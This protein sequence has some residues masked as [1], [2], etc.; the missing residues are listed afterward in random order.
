MDTQ[1]V[2]YQ[3]GLLLGWG[4]C[5]LVFQKKK[6]PFKFMCNPTLSGFSVPRVSILSGFGRHLGLTDAFGFALMLVSIPCH[7]S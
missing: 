3:P 4:N 1:T 5:L 7:T 6:M 2:P